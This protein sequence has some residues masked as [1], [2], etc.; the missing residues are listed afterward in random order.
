MRELHGGGCE[1]ERSQIWKDLS[2]VLK[3]VSFVPQAVRATEF[4][5]F[6]LNGD[7]ETFSLCDSGYYKVIGS[8]WGVIPIR[9]FFVFK[10]LCLSQSFIFH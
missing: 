8:Y 4:C 1:G 2:I 5:L 3:T 10:T 6:V 7:C 9:L